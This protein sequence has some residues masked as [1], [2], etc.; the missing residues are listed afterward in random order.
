MIMHNL[1]PFNFFFISSLSIYPHVS[2]LW[3]CKQHL[4]LFHHEKRP[5]HHQLHLLFQIPSAILF[6]PLLLSSCW[7]YSDFSSPA[8]HI[9]FWAVSFTSSSSKVTMCSSSSAS[10]LLSSLCSPWCSWYPARAFVLW[11]HTR[12]WVPCLGS[13]TVHGIAAG[14]LLHC[15]PL[16]PIAAAW[17]SSQIQNR[18][19]VHV[20]DPFLWTEFQIVS[21]L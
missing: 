7:W 15:L 19:L 5:D 1:R 13:S 21:S 20:L 12:P 16:C 3:F 11:S 17:F 9:S 6:S 14:S 18:G 2:F 4:D 8:L 10:H